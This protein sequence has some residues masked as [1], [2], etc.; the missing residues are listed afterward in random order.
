MQLKAKHIA[1]PASIV[2]V[3]L[4]ALFTGGPR[5]PMD[6]ADPGAALSAA[7]E[8]ELA[9][10]EGEFG[11]PQVLDNGVEI[12]ITAPTVFEPSD[13]ALLSAEGR[14]QFLNVTVEN[15][16]DA[17]LD[18]SAFTVV[19][20][21]LG[22]VPDQTCL[23]S[24]DEAKGVVGVPFEPLAPGAEV[25]FPWVIVCPTEAG[26]TLE[27]SVSITEGQQVTFRGAVA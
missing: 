10:V 19:Q 6:L 14:P 21:L 5:V 27:L 15:G 26:D 20:T 7:P 13:P 2:S 9:N 25:S 8:Q 22:A 4:I 1:I 24:F 17:D 12:T 3:V 11:A 18:L 23:D 16:T